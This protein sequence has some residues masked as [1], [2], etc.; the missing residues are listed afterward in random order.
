MPGLMATDLD[1]IEELLADQEKAIRDAFRDFISAMNSQAVTDAIAAKLENRDVAG[2]MAIVESYIARLGNVIPAI[3]ATVGAFTANELAEIV[4]H[5]VPDIVH[6]IS[7]DPSFP[8]AAEIVQAHRAQFVSYFTDQQRRATSQ[9]LARSF[10]EGTHAISTARAFRD[11]IGLTPDQEQWVANYRA[12]LVNRNRTALARDLRDRRFDGRVQAAIDN[13][14]PLTDK[15]IDTMVDRYRKNALQM[16]AET[17]AR[18]EGGQATSE[19]REE[20]KTQMIEQTGI[21]PERVEEMWNATRDTHTRDWHA[22]MNGQLRPIGVPFTDGLGNKLRYPHDPQAP[23][24][25]R[26]NCRCT[27]TFSIRPAA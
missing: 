22:S 25:T 3:A 1:R 17:I 7:F 27:K 21:D 8:R 24:N 16:R 6:A 11:S 13:N 23:L 10:R 2:A 14:R 19:A 5:S 12:S 4:S 15:Q 20:A 26:I 18:T 9:A